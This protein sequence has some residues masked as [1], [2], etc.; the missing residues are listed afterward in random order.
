MDEPAK[1]VITQPTDT[2]AV[3]A[4]SPINIHSCLSCLTHGSRLI[5]TRRR[6]GWLQAITVLAQP[7]NG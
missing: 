6:M 1:S 3:S 7:I 2:H 4:T 5:G